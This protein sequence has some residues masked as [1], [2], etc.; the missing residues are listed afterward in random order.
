MRRNYLIGVQKEKKLVLFCRLKF[1]ISAGFQI[2]VSVVT[3][4]LVYWFERIIHDYFWEET[5][6]VNIDS[7]IHLLFS[8][9][10]CRKEKPK[11]LCYLFP[12]TLTSMD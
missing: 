10:D 8:F 9:L 2:N 7:D 6:W 12:L 4:D 5:S 11:E 1:I 3:F